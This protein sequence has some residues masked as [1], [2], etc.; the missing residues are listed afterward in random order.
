MI[1]RHENSNMKE[2]KEIID[3]LRR[4]AA[5]S[6]FHRMIAPSRSSESRK[7]RAIA[8]L[9][10]ADGMVNEYGMFLKRYREVISGEGKTWSIDIFLVET[11]K[12]IWY[13]GS[14]IERNWNGRSGWVARLSGP[15]LKGEP[16]LSRDAALEAIIDRLQ[17]IYQ[18][19]GRETE[20]ELAAIKS[21]IGWLESQ[22]PS[23]PK[24]LSMFEEVPA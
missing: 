9:V 21:V 1:S 19:D 11:R 20:R 15:S 10:D 16:F 18:G 22:R 8:R 6:R 13:A 4:F 5:K 17:K 14:D 7:I 12:G 24:Q 2:K 3:S 23:T